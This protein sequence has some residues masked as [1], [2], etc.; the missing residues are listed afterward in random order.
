MTI[1]GLKSKAFSSLVKYH[2]IRSVAVVATDRTTL[3]L[4]SHVKTTNF[5]TQILNL[6]VFLAAMALIYQ[7]RHLMAKCQK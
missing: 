3:E 1:K 2:A 5:I 6:A 7:Q 4:A